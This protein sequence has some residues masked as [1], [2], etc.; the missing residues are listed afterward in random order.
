MPK[1]ILPTWATDATYTSGLDSGLNT[2]L[3]PTTG[4]KAQG[5]F[6][7]KKAPARKLNWIIGLLCDWAGWQEQARRGSQFASYTTVSPGANTR[8]AYWDSRVNAFACVADDSPGVGGTLLKYIWGA[9]AAAQTA[10][11]SQVSGTGS[12]GATAVPNGDASK[13]MLARG[14]TSNGSS[15]RL[16]VT[17]DAGETWT[18]LV[19]SQSLQKKPAVCWDGTRFVVIDNDGASIYHY[20]T[21]LT[22]LASAGLPAEWST[23]DL[24]LQADAGGRIVAV[25]KFHT[26]APSVYSD[27]GGATW[28]ASPIGIQPFDT[29]T[30]LHWSSALGWVAVGLNPGDQACLWLSD[31][32]A[33]WTR[34]G[35]AYGSQPFVH[36]GHPGVERAGIYHVTSTEFAFCA[37]FAFAGPLGTI[38]TAELAYSFDGIEWWTFSSNADFPRAIAGSPSGLAVVMSNGDVRVYA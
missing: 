24:L 21:T 19:L 6:R 26:S 32:G 8:H 11:G 25:P 5:L 7:G 28:T 38:D 1:P 16:D 12:G 33:T 13:V 17:L 31:D 2:R 15:G 36:R 10:G 9:D 18:Q 4:E 20:T 29:I 35:G 3:A 37:Y 22:P 27:D 23:Y 14:R 30:D 34:I